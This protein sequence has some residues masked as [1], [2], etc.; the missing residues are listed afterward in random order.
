MFNKLEDKVL[1][2]IVKMVVEKIEVVDGVIISMFE[3]DYV[4]LVFLMN[5]LSWL[6]YGIFLFVDKLVMIIGVFYGMLGFFRV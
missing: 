6:F 3:Y 5:V 1:L 4:V 2:E